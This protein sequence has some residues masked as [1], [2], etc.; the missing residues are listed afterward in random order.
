MFGSHRT[1]HRHY[2]KSDRSHRLE[3][4]FWYNCKMLTGKSVIVTKM[5]LSQKGSPSLPDHSA[6]ARKPRRRE[7]ASSQR[8][9]SILAAGLAVFSADGFAAAK[10]D[11]V[12]AKADV[13]K[14]TIYLH[15]RDKQDLFEQIVRTAMEP[16]IGQLERTVHVPD[17]PLSVL[18]AKL[19][20]LYRTQVLGTDRKLVIRLVL[21]EGARF[22]AIADFYHREVISRGLALLK[23]AMQRGVARG[24]IAPADPEYFPHLVFAPLV[25]ALMWDGLFSA[26]EPIDIERLLAAHRATLLERPSGGRPA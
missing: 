19:F 17:I 11:D 13:A 7:E 26:F 22:P 9:E 23:V 20:D 4:G 6:P 12:A 8:R 2:C 3:C 16:V 5:T 21:T 18:L 24:E 25:L 10:L 15:F 1:P 14:G